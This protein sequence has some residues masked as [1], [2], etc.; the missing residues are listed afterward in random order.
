MVRREKVTDPRGRAWVY[1]ELDSETWFAEV[2][3]HARE[4]AQRVIDQRLRASQPAGGRRP[5]RQR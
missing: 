3:R 2:R 5:M 1:G 4:E